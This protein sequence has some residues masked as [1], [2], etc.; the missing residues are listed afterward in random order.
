M[1][2][3][4]NGCPFNLEVPCAFLELGLYLL[5]ALQKSLKLEA[6]ANE[7]ADMPRED[8]VFWVSEYRAIVD[9]QAV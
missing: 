4:I 8:I 5:N 7:L 2:A 6:R 1:P 9:V 3:I